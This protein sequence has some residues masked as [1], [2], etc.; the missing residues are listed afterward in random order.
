MTQ[1]EG[2]HQ[3]QSDWI[4]FLGADDE[5]HSSY[6]AKVVDQ[7]SRGPDAGLVCACVELIGRTERNTLRP[8]IIPSA[9]PR[10]FPPEMYKRLLR[11]GDNY[12]VG[13]VTLYQQTALMALGGFNPGLESLADGVL[14]R[15]IAL[16]YGFSFI[17]EVLGYWRRHGDYY[18]VT[19]VTRADCINP[20][21]AHMRRRIVAEQTPKFEP[22]YDKRLERRVRFNGAPA[23]PAGA[24]RPGISQKRSADGAS[25]AWFPRPGCPGSAIKVALEPCLGM[26]RRTHAPDVGAKILQ[27]ILSSPIDPAGERTAIFLSAASGFARTVSSV[28]HTLSRSKVSTQSKASTKSSSSSSPEQTQAPAAWPALGLFL[29]S[30]GLFLTEGRRKIFNRYRPSLRRLFA[31]LS[32]AADLSLQSTAFG[33]RLL[34]LAS[35]C[36]AQHGILTRTLLFAIKHGLA[37]A[38]QIHL[39]ARNK[40]SALR[41]ARI[42]NLLFGCEIRA[43]TGFSARADAEALFYCGRYDEI[44]R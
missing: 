33:G 38:V 20:P 9:E 43:H 24:R 16:R 31:P 3:V 10:Y 7:L 41:A 32:A 26:A 6:L 21:L 40:E 29:T 28:R 25:D 19:T 18:F 8:P 14:A 35:R 22:D 42:G 39:A 13:T 2:I 4:L 1:N 44:T 30:I 23:H 17:P 37:A 12:H 15:Q 27:P 5:L 34:H 11:S 36:V